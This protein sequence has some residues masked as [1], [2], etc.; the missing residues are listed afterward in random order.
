MLAPWYKPTWCSQML[1]ISTSLV[2]SANRALLRSKSWSS[3]RSRPSVPSTSITKMLS[4]MRDSLSVPPSP[5]FLLFDIQIP[6]VVCLRSSSDMTENC[7][8]KR[9]LSRV[10]LPVD[11]EPNTEMRW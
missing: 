3:P 4:A 2:A 10:D 11:C 9:W 6:F 1:T 7:V 5:C 8:P